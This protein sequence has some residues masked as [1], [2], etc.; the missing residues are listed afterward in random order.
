MKKW[1]SILVLLFVAVSSFGQIEF[2]KDKVKVDFSIDRDGDEAYVIAKV[3][4]VD[5]WHINAIKLPN[6]VFGF[7]SSFTLTENANF[8]V[9]GSPIEPKAHE[10][11][12]EAAKEKQVYH[13]GRFKIKQKIKI[14]TDKEF[15]IPVKFE[16]QTCNAVMCLPPDNY[17]ANVKV[18]AN[19][20]SDTDVPEDTA[21]NITEI[22]DTTK[23]S[24]DTASIAAV[25][26]PDNKTDNQVD[27]EKS[28][29]N[30]KEEEEEEESLWG[31]FL[32]SMGAG[33]LA[34]LTPCVFPM[35]PM[36]VSFFTK[37]SKS[38]AVGRRNAIIYGIS[39][40]VIYII[41]GVVVT[42]IFGG[43]AL[44]DMAA[45]PTFNLIFFIIL[46]VF[47]ISFMGAFEIRLPSKWVNKADQRA[48]KGGIVGIFFMA[49]ALAL[50]SFSCTGPIVGGLI[51]K[52]AGE[53][54]MAPIIGMFGFSLALALPFTLF[55]LFP[56][57][58]NSLPKSGGWLNVVKV[59]L[60]LLELAF[61]LKFLSNWDFALQ[62]HFL[63]REIFIALW[64]AIFGVLALYLFG[65]IRLPH[66]SPI[67]KLKVG[68]TIFATIVLAFTIYMIP[69]LWGAPLKLI[70][71]FPPPM[72]YSESPL[73]FG[74]SGG[75][76][77]SSEHIEGTH[78]GPQKIMVFHDYDLARAH[79]EKVNKPLFVD[80]T[81]YTCVNCRKMEE[82]V[83][84][85]DGIIET[86]R[87][88]VVIVSLHTDDQE[89]LPKEE[90][91]TIDIGNGRTMEL[92]TYGDK[93][94]AKQILD[95]NVLAQPYYVMEFA[96]GGFIPNGE[97]TYKDHSNPKDFKAWLDKG[98]K[99][100]SEN[101]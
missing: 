99:L 15:D 38:K 97:A 96:K 77:S 19:K 61:A 94:K 54:G 40:I 33:F 74:G 34:L 18:I 53:G 81:G 42:S 32:L 92:T 62:L 37:Q 27:T 14:L 22:T 43:A 20:T 84:G 67:E 26:G 17:T 28:T 76:S 64:I 45:S 50:V 98:M 79:A 56:S 7:P 9:V 30:N 4:V 87:N 51:M 6:D 89:D 58:M 31:I 90:Q 49:L 36:T 63:E 60:G 73:G 88:D 16:F 46:V 41:L 78:L 1:F 24:N 95:H 83:W 48:D 66:D 57:L 12:D 47:A 39:I 75:P 80:Y 21:S 69:G 86:L 52:A 82:T 8:K 25:G 3:N 29:D 101:K 68:R 35:I 13:E 11:Y 85:E 59:V 10:Y 23:N 72:N 100:A 44:N 65:K 5:E 93:W 71:A 91:K 70:S 2:G 55:A